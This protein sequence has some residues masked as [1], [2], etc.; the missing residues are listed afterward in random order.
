MGVGAAAVALGFLWGL[1]F[2]VIKKLWT[3]SYVLVAG[4][5][6]ALLLGLFHQII[7]V[8]KIQFW[9]QPFLWVGSN[10][11]T[12]YLVNN[13]MGFGTVAQRFAGGD[14][15]KWMDTSIAP[16]AG[17]LLLAV[18][19]VGLGLALCRFLYRRKIFIRL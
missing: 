10:A 2:P 8:Q 19:A 18:V 13:L 12:I 9:I 7:E 14:V 6:S 15:K 4:G 5:Y 16:G 1:Q 17:D 3:S 11:I